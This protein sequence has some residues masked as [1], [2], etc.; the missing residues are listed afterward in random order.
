M[1]MVA[2]PSLW[3]SGAPDWDCHPEMAINDPRGVV[4]FRVENKMGLP[5]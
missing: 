2:L 4:L 1:V 5:S 3:E